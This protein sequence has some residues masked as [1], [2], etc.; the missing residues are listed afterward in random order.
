MALAFVT[1][2][3][4]G[5]EPSA[6]Q[7][8]AFESRQTTLTNVTAVMG[9]ATLYSTKAFFPSEGTVDVKRAGLDSLKHCKWPTQSMPSNALMSDK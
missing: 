8:L 4:L 9:I 7:I 2:V 6:Q 1:I 3:G 5:V